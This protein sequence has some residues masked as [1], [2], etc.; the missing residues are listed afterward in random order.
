M[1]GLRFGHHSTTALYSVVVQASFPSISV[2]RAPPSLPFLQDV[3]SQPTAV[4]CLSLLSRPHI[5]AGQ[6]P[7]RNSQAG[8]HGSASC[9]VELKEQVPAPSH[10]VSWFSLQ[11]GTQET[12]TDHMETMEENAH[13]MNK[14]PC[15]SEASPM[16]SLTHN[17]A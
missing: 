16:F 10:L 11:L 4:F 17:Y 5:L 6:T 14:H 7:L 12:G 9:R 1:V 8:P 2:C 13:T 15:R 3:P